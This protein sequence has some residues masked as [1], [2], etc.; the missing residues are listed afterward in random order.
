[1]ALYTRK[2]QHKSDQTYFVN[3]DIG[4][5]FFKVAPNPQKGDRIALKC[6]LTTQ[7]GGHNQ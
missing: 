3:V 5:S 1:V 7:Q 6:H 2:T 4:S